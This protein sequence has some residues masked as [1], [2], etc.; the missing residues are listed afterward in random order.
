MISIF[1]RAVLHPTTIR[2]S[3]CTLFVASSVALQTAVPC[4]AETSPVLLADTVTA[5]SVNP[6]QAA[7]Q[8]DELTRQILLK[9]IELQ[10]FNLHYTLEV[11]K[12]GRWKGW[13]Y[14]LFQ[15]ANTGL[16]LAG[17]IISANNRGRHIHHAERVHLHT[18]ESANYI[19][20]I[21]SIIGAGAA[22]ME[23]GINGYHDLIARK[24]G[25]SPAASLKRVGD[26]KEQINSLI[27]HRRQLM[28]R[29]AADPSLETRLL[30]DK[31]EGRV[32]E[33]MLD[34]TLQEFARYH[35]GARKLLAFQQTQYLFDAGKY[36]TNAIGSEFAYLSL[37]RRQ[38]IWNGRAGVLYAVAGQLTMW[39]PI[40]SRLCAKGVGEITKYRMRHLMEG[41]R[42][43][44]I[45]T[46]QTDLDTLDKLAGQET[47]AEGRLA[48]TVDRQAMFEGHERAFTNEIRRQEK[49]DDA[50]KLTA[51]QNIGAGAFVGA[52]KTAQAILFLIPGYNR[53]YNS[54]TERAGRVTN[55]LLFSSAVVGLP[56]SGFS[57]LDTLRIQVRGEIN[58]HRAAR[59][60]EL[61]GQ[62]AAARLKELDEMEQKLK[63]M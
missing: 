43:A 60:G 58:R 37:H 50:A 19:P 38:R 24:H 46:L 52:S 63:S 51:T 29:E 6:V 42:D 41:A 14:A 23:F 35:V 62:L 10:R 31:A 4:S 21:G 59:K 20:M 34:Q 45:A 36:T 56:A 7:D 8:V 26:L 18:Q 49:K 27:S 48:S 5:D 30:V 57:M 2:R 22:G 16:G 44:Q 3:W 12:Q 15:E 11:A 40:L 54:K 13:R 25:F 53:N 17:G 55:D 39:A 33:D 1:K 61:P 47:P 9:E 28:D 32:L